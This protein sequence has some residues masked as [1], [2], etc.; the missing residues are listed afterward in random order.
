MND[1]TAFFAELE[2]RD[3]FPSSRLNKETEFIESEVNRKSGV[4]ARWVQRSLN[5]VMGLKLAVDGD[6]GPITK[7]AIRKFQ[8]R[9]G[10]AVDASV[11]PNTER[12]LVT[13]GADRPPVSTPAAD[14]RHQEWV[15]LRRWFTTS[16]RPPVQP[17]RAGNQ[18]VTFVSGQATLA[19]MVRA[20][21]TAT[22]SGHF[23]YLLG[24]YLDDTFQLIPGDS[25]STIREL[26]GQASRA[27]VQVRAMLWDQSGS[28][29]DA[30][31]SHINALRSGA[32][33]LDN[34]TVSRAR[35]LGVNIGTHHQ[36]ILIVKGTKGLIAFCGGVDINC[37]RLPAPCPRPSSSS[38]GSGSGGSGSGSGSGGTGITLP[39]HD[40]HC[41]V[42]GP[43][44]HDLLR[45]FLERWQDHPD[46]VARDR[47]KGPLLG[48]RE[49]LPRPIGGVYV[50]SGRT[51]GNGRR[52]P[53]VSGGFRFAPNGEQSVRRM[54]LHAIHAA[55]RFIYIE[56]QY[57]INLEIS[58][59]LVRALPN[60]RHLTIL[61]A[62]SD[63]LSNDECPQRQHRARRD[64][65][66]PLR[67]AG[68]SKVRV[69]HLA[70]LRAPGS[71]VHS[72]MW[73]F[74]DEFAIIGSA[75]INRRGY[76]HDSEAVVGI[77]D[78][79]TPSLV[80]KLRIALWAKHLNLNTAAGRAVLD[81][82]VASARHWLTRPSGAQ[83][84]PFNERAGI[85]ASDAF[86]CRIASWDDHIDPDGS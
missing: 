83:A 69:F 62:H 60:I 75:N 40:V 1:M 55:R 2:A 32:A 13:A 72:K 37:N 15:G 58:R 76:T 68:G 25:T 9:E 46:H 66:T 11:G 6:I 85:S 35:P 57:L 79:A 22:G 73:V 41:Q 74:D 29:N 65:I 12:A 82:G 28:R 49:P 67:A 31:V 43:A 80:K 20:I 18:V 64:F 33:I 36:K 47:A 14:P 44:A 70:P 59:A 7:S 45:I 51:Y 24:W 10:L 39:L 50:Q 21:R 8:R 71:Y 86:R 27:G 23:I 48:L 42:R 84:A 81:D 77:Y 3:G 63:L 19:A 56:D 5:K 61:I 52:H 26:F 38:S 4:Y 53:G 30:E 16:G 17:V 34:R 54:V 78:P